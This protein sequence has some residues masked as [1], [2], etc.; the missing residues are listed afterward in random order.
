MPRN[1][2]DRRASGVAIVGG[3]RCS[4]RMANT[5]TTRLARAYF[6]GLEVEIGMS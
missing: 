3:G 2:R 5:H 4:H 6:V 1:M